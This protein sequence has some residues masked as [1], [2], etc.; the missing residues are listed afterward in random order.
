MYYQL[1]F[2]GLV[3]FAA[4][5]LA[6]LAAYETHRKPFDLVGIGGIF[7]LL[8]A[9][10][11]LGLS[12][13]IAPLHDIGTW[14]SV[15]RALM[16]CSFILGWVALGCGAVWSTVEVLRESDHSVLHRGTA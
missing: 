1:I 13:I 5:W 7:F 8:A 2:L 9:S 12:T 3:C 4:P 16:I 10:F 14:G 11:G 15:I 6:R